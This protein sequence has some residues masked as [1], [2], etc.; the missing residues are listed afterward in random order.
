MPNPVEFDYAVFTA[1]KPNWSIIDQNLQFIKN[2]TIFVEERNTKPIDTTDRFV[3]R[4][5]GAHDLVCP[6]DARPLLD[7]LFDEWPDKTP[8]IRVKGYIA[9]FIHSRGTGR[10]LSYD[11]DNVIAELPDLSRPL[12]EVDDAT[13]D[14]GQLSCPKI[15]QRG[16]VCSL[17]PLMHKPRQ[18]P[19]THFYQMNVIGDPDVAGYDRATAPF[20]T[21]T[22]PFNVR[23]YNLPFSTQG[24]GWDM[25]YTR[26]MF[27]DPFLGRC[28]DVMAGY[29][30]SSFL[31]VLV[32][33]AMVQGRNSHDM[34]CDNYEDAPIAAI[35]RYQSTRSYPLLVA[36]N[37]REEWVRWYEDFYDRNPSLSAGRELFRMWNQLFDVLEE[38]FNIEPVKLYNG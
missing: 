30:I 24:V 17:R 21:T 35:A 33:G 29:A 16:I 18:H 6:P 27:L 9:A 1:L 19:N 20:V 12:F 38:S 34:I 8:F 15:R 11:D 4:V 26:Y 22:A 13:F 5:C 31:P 32:G 37:I 7:K 25:A 3:Y 23:A 36:N 28:G 2:L 10:C 14:M